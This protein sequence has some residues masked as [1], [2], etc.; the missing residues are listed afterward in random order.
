MEWVKSMKKGCISEYRSE[1]ATS[2]RPKQHDM[3]QDYRLAVLS[4]A[5][6]AGEASGEAIGFDPQQHLLRQKEQR[7]R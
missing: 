7:S 3:E 4:A 6:R 5:I 1:S 2:D